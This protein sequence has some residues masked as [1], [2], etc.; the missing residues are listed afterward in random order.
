MTWNHNVS[1]FIC[2]NFLIFEVVIKL[3]GYIEFSHWSSILI[4]I[5][6]APVQI[7]H[8]LH[9]ACPYW[10]WFTPRLSIYWRIFVPRL[11]ILMLIHTAHVQ[12]LLCAFDLVNQSKAWLLSPAS[13]KWY[14]LVALLAI[15]LDSNQKVLIIPLPC[16]REGRLLTRL[17]TH[18][19][20]RVHCSQNYMRKYDKSIWNWVAAKCC[21][22]LLGVHEPYLDLDFTPQTRHKPAHFA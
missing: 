11:S 12:V 4:L 10:C 17:R 9:R 14:L 21:Y 6:T 18:P 15:S 20:R 16:H 5:Y 13:G 7:D 19:G 2:R 22:C 3:S 1:V 8:Y